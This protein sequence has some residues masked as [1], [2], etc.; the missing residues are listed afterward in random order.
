MKRVLAILPI[1]VLAAGCGGGSSPS[2]T[3]PSQAALT[4][5]TTIAPSTPAATAAVSI[6]GCPRP[7]HYATDRAHTGALTAHTYS[8]AADV[9]AALKYDQLSS[10]ARD[11]F[12]HRVR[13]PKSAVNGVVSCVALQ[14][15]TPHLAGRFFMSYRALRRPA[16]SIV[17][18][19]TPEPSLAGL[20]GTTTYFEKKQTFRGYGIS[21]TNVIEASGRAGNTLY[22]ASVAGPSPSVSLAR[23]LLKSMASHS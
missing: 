17:H 21:S 23:T 4:T 6:R 10:G 3:Q 16:K 22:I 15:A 13:S 11:V 9:Q 1:A 14:F 20:A 8:A 12:L 7:A 5:P 2:A 19:I 18:E